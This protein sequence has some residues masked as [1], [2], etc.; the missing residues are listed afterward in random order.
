MKTGDY[1][2]VLKNDIHTTIMATIDGEGH[3]VTRVIDVMLVDDKTLYFITAKGKEFYRQLM[4]Q[5]FVS[6]SGACGGEGMDKKEASIHMS[7]IS[8]R[9][10]VQNIGS[11]RL[12]EVFEKNPYMYE[13]YPDVASRKAL[14]VFCITKGTG[15]F[16]DL[17]TKPIRRERFAVG[18]QKRKGEK[19]SNGYY[20]TDACIGCKACFKVCPQKCIEADSVPF[21]I[22]QENCLHCGNCMVTCQF[23]AI[24]DQRS[25]L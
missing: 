5:R 17:S 21:K 7:A 10:T 25:S 15:E 1:L 3:P 6:I 13:I 20:I 23:G 11:Q 2:Q 18:L 16:F 22:R 19:R 12:E 14:E 4:E 9:G 8:I 24:V